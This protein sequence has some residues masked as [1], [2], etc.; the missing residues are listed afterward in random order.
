MAG[1]HAGGDHQN[2]GPHGREDSVRV[3]R[4]S[5][6]NQETSDRLPAKLT[7]DIETLVCAIRGHVI[8]A[9]RVAV[10][11]P[12]DRGFGIDVHPTWRIS[13]CLRCDAWIGGPP[14][15]APEHDRLPP[16]HQLDLPRRGHPLRQAVILRII[17]VERAIHAVIFAAIAILGV[18]LR[19]HLA[20]AQ[21]A[22]QRYLET[23]ART[24]AQT[25]RVNNHSILARE[26]TAFLHL[27][28]STLEVLI[29]TAAIYAIV[30]GTE[31]VGL[32]CE[33]RWA[34]YLTALATAGFVPFEIHELVKR[35]TVVRA[36]ALVVNVGIVVYL[37]FA[38]HLF[39]VNKS[40]AEGGPGDLP[41]AGSVFSPPF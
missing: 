39:G 41:A 24:E 19:S 17:S 28:S 7:L 26:G 14:P 30:E 23:L 29:I 25:G 31:A 22:V 8:P 40:R 21:G 10:L 11:Q 18:V 38:K 34:E 32:W 13:R 12:E 37:V 1:S 20:N 15:E 36:G 35:V 5:G 16:V 2:A 27:K 33:K 6:K 3:F 4:I 9:S